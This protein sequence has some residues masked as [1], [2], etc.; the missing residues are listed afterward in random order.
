MS[1]TPLRHSP[2]FCLC[3]KVTHGAGAGS[4]PETCL[5][6]PQHLA[7]AGSHCYILGSSS[8]YLGGGT[9]GL[10]WPDPTNH[11]SGEALLLQWSVPQRREAGSG[12]PSGLSI[13][14]AHRAVAQ[15]T[16][17]VTIPVPAPVCGPG[18]H[19]YPGSSLTG[20]GPSGCLTS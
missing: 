2:A 4:I 17:R 3:L 19:P 15:V 9:A 11:R 6:S 20:Q 8:L 1:P 5:E 14:L 16:L 13:P 18:H 10:G 12:G 7:Q